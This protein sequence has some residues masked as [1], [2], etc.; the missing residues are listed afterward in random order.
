MMVR[1]FSPTPSEPE[2]TAA[3]GSTES[4]GSDDDGTQAPAFG[5]GLLLKTTR[6]TNRRITTWDDLPI[7]PPPPP[8][9]QEAIIYL[10]GVG[11]R[12]FTALAVRQLEDEK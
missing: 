6:P 11:M 8:W 12:T 2:N 10:V 9:A 3:A 7:P 4:A 1:R 5:E